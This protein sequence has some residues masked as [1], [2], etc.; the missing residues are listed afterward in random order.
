VNPG[1]RLVTAPFFL[2]ALLAAG[3]ASAQSIVMWH[4]NGGT[5][6]DC[7]VPPPNQDFT[8]VA[9]GNYH[10]MGLKPDGSIV[11]W[12][13]CDIEQCQ[14]PAPNSGFLKISAGDSH[15]LGLRPGGVLAVWGSNEQG[16]GGVPV[17]NGGFV[18]MAGGAMHNL[19]LRADG[20]IECW[21]HSAGECAIP[22]PNSGWVAVAAGGWFSMGLRAD[23][24][25]HRW[26]NCFGGPQCP[27][28]PG[29]NTG[30]VA[31]ATSHNHALGLKANGSIVAWGDN[32]SGQLDVPEPNSGFTAIAAGGG[33]SLALRSD[34]SIAC[35]GNPVWCGVP[36]P[37]A[38]YVA[39]AANTSYWPH[40]L[41][42]E[43]PCQLNEDCDDGVFC[44]G[45]EAC[46]AGTCVAGPPPCSEPLFCRESDDACVQCLTNAQCD[47]GLFCN[48]TETCGAN[49]TCQAGSDPCPGQSCNESTNTCS[50]GPE[51]WLSFTGAT[52][53]PGVGTVAAQ[54]IVARNVGSGTW[55]MVFDGSDVGLGGLTIDGMARLG[56]GSILLSFTAAANIPGMTG[57]PNGTAL[58]DSDMVRF[59]P[60]SLGPTTTGSFVF[61][62]DGSDVGLTNDGEDVDAI[63]LTSGGQIMISTAGNVTANGASGVNADLLLFNATNLGSVTSGSFTLHVDGSDVGLTNNTNEDVDAAAI[64]GN[65]ILLSTTGNFSVPG[66][67]GADEDVVQFNP[68]SLGAQTA[69]TW[70]MHLDLSAFGIAGSADVGS[71]EVVP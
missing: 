11:A 33:F 34:G 61:Y 39:V 64:S 54:D 41:R 6:P 19:A 65:P 9:V 23:G 2:A 22:E 45:P 16:Q 15:S 60:T 31:M 27:G 53:V 3:A 8:A 24:S 52:S 49:G 63:A 4:C 59:V 56:D 26:G 5:H 46:N 62:F 51:L 25:I 57:G 37:N 48:G 36:E 66:V 10:T 7:D 28:P 13:L 12:G 68:T 44:N 55:S 1:T 21:G 47:D 71:V 42:A 32:D 18:D 38:G 58:D 70:S 40:A 20:T 14:V 29:E 67:S 69:G 43:A 17:P 50:G 30:F 35:F